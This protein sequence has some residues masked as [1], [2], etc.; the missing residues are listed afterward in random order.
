MSYLKHLKV[1]NYIVTTEG[2]SGR[3]VTKCETPEEVSRALGD[4]SFGA[5]T[6]V[7]SPTGKDV[8]EF[9]PF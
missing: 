8:S 4:C 3:K 9:V 2:W 7:D 1:V 5:L 6:M